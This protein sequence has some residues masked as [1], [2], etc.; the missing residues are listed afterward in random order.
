L[1]ELSVG[2]G[3][4]Y[5]RTGRNRMRAAERRRTA[6]MANDGSIPPAQSPAVVAVDKSLTLRLTGDRGINTVATIPR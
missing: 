6:P 5:Q 4:N 2:G 1:R 3:G